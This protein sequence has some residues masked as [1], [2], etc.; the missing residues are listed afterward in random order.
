MTTTRPKGTNDFLPEDTV[1]WQYVESVL[2][3]LAL[4]YGFEELR[5]QFLN[6]G[7]FFAWGWRN[8]RY[9]Q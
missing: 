6:H 2:R 1:K 5:T 8:Y 3:E 9:C 4:C 7:T